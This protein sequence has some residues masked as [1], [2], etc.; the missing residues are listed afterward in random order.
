[1]GYQ[2]AKAIAYA[3]LIGVL[4]ATPVQAY[5]KSSTEPGD[6][7]PMGGAFVKP[8][9]LESEVDGVREFLRTDPTMHAGFAGAFP[10]RKLE[11][12]A[13]LYTMSQLRAFPFRYS[14]IWEGSRVIHADY[15]LPLLEP[16]TQPRID[17]RGLTFTPDPTTAKCLAAKYSQLDP[18]QEVAQY[19][20]SVA[21][22]LPADVSSEEVIYAFVR[23]QAII[24]D[25]AMAEGERR[26]ASALVVLPDSPLFKVVALSIDGI[27]HQVIVL[28]TD[29][30][31]YRSVRPEV[32]APC[33][34][35]T[36]V[37]RK[38]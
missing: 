25:E 32:L 26:A 7:K 4:A 14:R 16:H 34:E 1:M 27:M 24:R 3:A 30:R 38:P 5:N 10:G 33:A 13:A 28:R 17:S 15:P 31:I 9:S 19:G 2:Y 22:L 23:L 37:P 18:A 36:P 29:Y 21:V 11:E 12:I 6:Q 20:K 8:P 35:S